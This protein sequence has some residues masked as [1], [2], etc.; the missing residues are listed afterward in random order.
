MVQELQSNVI[1]RGCHR[2]V[3]CSLHVSERM[4]HDVKML[5]DQRSLFRHARRYTDPA[6]PGDDHPCNIFEHEEFA[7]S[8][9]C[10]SVVPKALFTKPHPHNFREKHRH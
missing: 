5:D 1:L 8:Y 6:T 7:T 10:Y 3:Q 4:W 2:V 9:N